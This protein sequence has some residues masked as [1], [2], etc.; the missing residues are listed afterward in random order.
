LPVEKWIE[1]EKDIHERSSLD[2]NVF[3][4]EGFRI[5][6]Y[7]QWVNRLC[8]AIKA[9]DRGQSFICAVAH[10]NIAGMAKQG[11]KP[12]I[13][14]CDAG[15]LKMVV[16]IFVRGEFIGAVGACG[17]LLDDSEVDSFMI[18]RTIDMD[19][20]KIESLSNDL[21]RITTEAAETLGKY[22]SE[23]IDKIISDFEQK[24]GQ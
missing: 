10:M 14:E 4:T 19:E 9:D 11:E 21:K 13:V 6:D 18:K 7:K 8:P 3:N 1:L 15:L 17:V 12:A 5:T 23:R 22:I 24:K 16:P 20:E 2:A